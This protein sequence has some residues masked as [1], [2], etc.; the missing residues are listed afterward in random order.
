MRVAHHVAKVRYTEVRF[1]L[2]PADRRSLTFLAVDD[3]RVAARKSSLNCNNPRKKQRAEFVS[4]A[5][6]FRSKKLEKTDPPC[7]T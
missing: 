3:Q 6:T 7:P 2:A 4:R 5:C 1:R